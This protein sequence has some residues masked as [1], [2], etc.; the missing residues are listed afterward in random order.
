MVKETFGQIF[1]LERADGLRG[2]WVR[3]PIEIA[4]C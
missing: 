4:L 1:Y 3:A 2:I